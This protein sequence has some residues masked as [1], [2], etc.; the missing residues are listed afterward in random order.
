MTIIKSYRLIILISIT[1][2]VSSQL[3]AQSF[4]N[5]SWAKKFKNLF[6]SSE[7][8]PEPDIYV[9]KKQSLVMVDEPIWLI[10][11][12]SYEKFYTNLMT[13][14]VIGN[15]DINLLNGEARNDEG[16]TWFDDGFSGVRD[17]LSNVY[18]KLLEK[19]KHLE[20][21]LLVTSYGDIIDQSYLSSIYNSFLNEK[22]SQNKMID[23]LRT[24]IRNL[25]LKLKIQ[26]HQIGIIFDIQNIP[27]DGI[28]SEKVVN[29][30]TYIK[31]QLFPKGS[32]SKIG[33]KLPNLVEENSIYY[34]G[35]TLGKIGPLFDFVIYKNY[36]LD[37]EKVASPEYLEALTSHN[38][39]N[40]RKGIDSLS[41]MG[42]NKH[43]IIIEFAYTGLLLDRNMSGFSLNRILSY[44]QI[45]K[46]S[47][48]NIAARSGNV[49]ESEF[50]SLNI[51]DKKD[52]TYSRVIYEDHQVRLRKYKLIDS[53]GARGIC[54]HGIGYTGNMRDQQRS[55][56]WLAVAEV[57]GWIPDKL[58]W[59][60]IGTILGFMSL[61]FPYSVY[62]FWQVRNVLAKFRRHLIPV[63]GIWFL[64]TFGFFFC[65]N[66]IP[67][68]T[69]GVFLGL[70]F[71]LF[72]VL[73]ILFR[74]YILRIIRLFK[75]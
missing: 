49:G 20:F 34:D 12:K 29:F 58:Y 11:N 2:L 6:S 75:K 22:E 67:R 24:I 70:G 33:L 8:L 52:E 64:L 65:F 50:T 55:A 48:S 63:G 72:F 36:C 40:L 45:D 59:Y 28:Q 21:Y 44:N 60:I 37:F 57:Y 13:S 16:T 32:L 5:R 46:L 41:R 54:L 31:E 71:V 73:L 23:N 18:S 47:A 61:G 17:S 62:K 51:I 53:L 30:Y 25:Q 68:N 4:L 9:L 19:N 42:I 14:V 35:N 1:A 10:K 7:K 15:Y 39:A 74:I 66:F 43:D 69:L 56:L 38:T 3:N 27:K 26:E